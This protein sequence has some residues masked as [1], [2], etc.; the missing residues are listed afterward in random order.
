VPAPP[1]NNPESRI[2]NTLAGQKASGS[3]GRAIV[4]ERGTDDAEFGPAV[5]TVTATVA[6]LV[7]LNVSG[8]G[9]TVQVADAGAPLQL[10]VIDWLIAVPGVIVIWY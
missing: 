4:G 3:D 6:V 5:C 8:F 2:T 9:D 7:P 10:R 1:S